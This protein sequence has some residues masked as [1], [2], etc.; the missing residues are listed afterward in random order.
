MFGSL[1]V[2]GICINFENKETYGEFALHTLHYTLHYTLYTTHSTL[3]TVQ[4]SVPLLDTSDLNTNVD[5]T[6][7]IVCILDRQ[8]RKAADR[9][10]MQDDISSSS[11]L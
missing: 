11:L 8:S 9:Q 4:D 1:C 2:I 10:R 3:H 7:L 5:N 6:V